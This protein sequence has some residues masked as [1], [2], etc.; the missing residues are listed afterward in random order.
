MAVSLMG[1]NTVSF[2]NQF[3]VLELEELKGRAH[4]Q[5]VVLAQM[6]Y[7]IQQA[8]YLEV[9]DRDTKKLLFI[10]EAWSMLTNEGIAK[11]IERYRKQGKDVGEAIE[12]VLRD[13]E[14]QYGKS[15]EV[16]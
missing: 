7:Q 14:L 2:N 15:E 12:L 3:T 10:D 1:K 13:R 6:L 9:E 5:Q 16:A 4:L 8:I 11:A